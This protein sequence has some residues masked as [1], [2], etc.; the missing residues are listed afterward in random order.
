MAS[1]KLNIKKNT[2]AKLNECCVPVI[3]ALM[4]L[5]REKSCMNLRE[6]EETEEQ[7]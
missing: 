7:I 2:Q 1:Y 5:K 6:R 3:P 4:G